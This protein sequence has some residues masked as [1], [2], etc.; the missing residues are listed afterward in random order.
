MQAISLHRIRTPD[1]VWINRIDFTK[2]VEFCGRYGPL[3]LSR[4]HYAEPVD[5][6][7]LGCSRHRAT[8]AGPWSVGDSN[9][10]MQ[11][12]ASDPCL[13]QF[14]SLYYTLG[15]R[16]CFLATRLTLGISSSIAEAKQ[17]DVACRTQVA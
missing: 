14:D 10:R 9:S 17:R 8:K 4:R 7:G 12:W 15:V 11:K 2:G 5:V 13:R 16:S 1:Q 6:A 3:L